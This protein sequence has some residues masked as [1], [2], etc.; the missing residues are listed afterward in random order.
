MNQSVNNSLQ[1]GI[2]YVGFERTVQREMDTIVSNNKKVFQKFLT[3]PHF[4]SELINTIQTNIRVVYLNGYNINCADLAPNDSPVL[5]VSDSD[6]FERVFEWIKNG[7]CGCISYNNLFKELVPA[8][9]SVLQNKI[10]VSPSFFPVLDDDL[11][12]KC[13]G[14]PGQ[15]HLFTHREINL[16]ELLTRG[17]LY[18]EIASELQISENTVRSHI[19]HIYSKLK[20]HSKTELTMKIINGKMIS[21]LTCFFVDCLRML[22]DSIAYLCY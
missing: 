10:Y 13:A 8:L 4:N 6:S 14:D 7:F 1:F 5:C 16:I 2:S 17:A 11:N 18:K 20:V 22:F 19:R 9:V 21:A 3:L 15:A 12:Y